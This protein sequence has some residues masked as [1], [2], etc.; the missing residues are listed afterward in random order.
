M[1]FGPGTYTLGLLALAKLV[2]QVTKVFFSHFKFYDQKVLQCHHLLLDY[3]LL[4]YI[5]TCLCDFSGVVVAF[6]F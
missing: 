1:H 3:L 5:C 6:I 4:L 2:A